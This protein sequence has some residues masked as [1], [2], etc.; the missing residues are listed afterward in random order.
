MKLNFSW[1]SSSELKGQQIIMKISVLPF[2][3][4]LFLFCATYV[5][6][7]TAVDHG[8]RGIS[9]SLQDNGQFPHRPNFADIIIIID[10]NT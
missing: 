4:V 2:C 8:S 1:C 9:K 5:F 10:S 7:K 3:L 6:E